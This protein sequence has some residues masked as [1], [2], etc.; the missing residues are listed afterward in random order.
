[1]ERSVLCLGVYE[2]E[3]SSFMTDTVQKGWTALD[4]GANVGIHTCRIA[5]LVG[6]TGR[7]FAFEP[8]PE[9]RSRLEANL[10]LNGLKNV[11]VVPDG[12]SDS[13]GHARLFVNDASNPNRNSTLVADPEN[14]KAA[15]ITITL[16]R[17][18]EFW[19]REAHGLPVH[20]V[21]IDIEGFEFAALRSGEK[22]L[23]T[24]R[25]IILSEFSQYYAA[26]LGYSWPELHAWYLGLKYRLFSTRGA[27][28]SS[29]LAFHP[30][31]NFNY[32]AKPF[33]S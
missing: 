22:M 29:D 30:R 26:L 21:K 19:Q 10:R 13:P 14:S 31:A 23:T 8:N 7:V 3:E 32:V 4:A 24:C 11:R 15:P 17:L 20:F 12:L 28:L 5:Y 2:E 18:D 1:M 6:A 27:A 16:R 9:V 25:P 33:H